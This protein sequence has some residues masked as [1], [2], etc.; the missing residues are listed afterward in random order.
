MKNLVGTFCILCSFTGAPVEIDISFQIFYF[1]KS[2]KDN[3][4]V[5]HLNLLEDSLVLENNYFA[6]DIL[7]IFMVDNWVNLV[8]YYFQSFNFM[9]INFC[10]NYLF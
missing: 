10:T 4:V 6:E 7:V 5:G 3:L 2:E 9:I 8:D 1:I